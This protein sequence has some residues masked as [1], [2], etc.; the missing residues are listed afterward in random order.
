MNPTELRQ[1]DVKIAFTPND[2]TEL[3]KR[4]PAQ[5]NL[6]KM[7]ELAALMLTKTPLPEGTAFTLSYKDSSE[8]VC[9]VEDDN[10]LQMAY[11]I[12]LSD[13]KKLKLNIELSLAQSIVQAFY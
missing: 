4:V 3:I 1:L 6:V 13:S 7:R 12:A 10:D 2:R 11:A 8:D 5:S 9:Q